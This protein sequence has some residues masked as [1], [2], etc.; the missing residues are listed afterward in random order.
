MAPIAAGFALGSA[1]VAGGATLFDLF[2]L[3][4]GADATVAILFV[5]A[6]I[7]LLLAGIL[8][9]LSVQVLR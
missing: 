5:L 8:F 2:T 1:V 3:P 4:P 6:L 9:V 7:A